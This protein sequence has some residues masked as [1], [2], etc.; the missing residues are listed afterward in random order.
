MQHCEQFYQFY[1]FNFFFLTSSN[2]L[3]FLTLVL[4]QSWYNSSLNTRQM[5]IAWAK[6][7]ITFS[8]SK[9]LSCPCL[10]STQTVLLLSFKLSSRCPS[11]ESCA[12]SWGS[13]ERQDVPQISSADT[14]C[15]HWQL[16]CH[17]WLDKT[18][19]KRAYSSGSPQKVRKGWRHG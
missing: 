5:K 15:S 9:S 16:R 19:R 8:L 17:G 13:W 12:E 7:Q 4:K 10:T 6:V 11:A 14:Y 2:F 3:K 18:K 1:Q